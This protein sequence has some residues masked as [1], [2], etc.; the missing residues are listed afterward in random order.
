MCI[1]DSYLPDTSPSNQYF[2]YA[3]GLDSTYVR[4][5]NEN[6]GSEISL[7]GNGITGNDETSENLTDTWRVIL[8]PE[9]VYGCTDSSACNYNSSANVENNT[10]WFANEGCSCAVS[11][12]HLTLPTKRIV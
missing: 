6:E 7:G 4:I 11:Y 1:R 12:T 10:C 3:H 9:I 8:T 5:S 2:F